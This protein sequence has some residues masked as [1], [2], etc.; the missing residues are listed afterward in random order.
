MIS[1]EEA[2]TTTS[3]KSSTESKYFL[4]TMAAVIALLCPTSS[5]TFWPVCRQKDFQKNKQEKYKKV[6]KVTQY[7]G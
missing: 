1:S 7:F 3:E 2:V 4:M 6:E 5:H